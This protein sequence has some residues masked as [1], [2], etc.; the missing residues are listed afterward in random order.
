M[1]FGWIA[2]LTYLFVAVCLLVPIYIAIYIYETLIKPPPAIT[3]SPKPRQSTILARYIRVI[4]KKTYI[5][6]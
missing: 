3:L 2:A 6:I 4:K 5:Y 1:T